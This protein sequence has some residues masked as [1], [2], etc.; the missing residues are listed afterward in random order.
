M[1]LDMD[2]S[3]RAQSRAALRLVTE[4]VGLPYMYS[5]YFMHSDWILQG[6][7]QV[8]EIVLLRGVLATHRLSPLRAKI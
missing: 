2:K 4:E 5:L 3:L 7:Q 8:P 1:H 6:D